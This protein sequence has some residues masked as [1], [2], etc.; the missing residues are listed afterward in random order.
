[1]EW[2]IRNDLIHLLAELFNKTSSCSV[3]MCCYL[4]VI[5]NQIAED[6]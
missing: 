1:M 2:F 4:V 6:G 3:S 5:L